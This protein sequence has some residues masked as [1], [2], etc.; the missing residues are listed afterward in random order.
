MI[1]AARTHGFTVQPLG[2]NVGYVS[3]DAASVTATWE[4]G[5]LDAFPGL[6]MSRR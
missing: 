3:V 5:A 4:A 6:S 1:A 2:A